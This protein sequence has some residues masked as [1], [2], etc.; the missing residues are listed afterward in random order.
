MRITQLLVVAFLLTLSGP[1]GAA[2][3]AIQIAIGRSGD[4]FILDTI[5]DFPVPVSTAWQVLTDFDHMV[6]VVSSLTMSKITAQNGNTLR[7]Q[8]SGVAKF[9]ILSYAFV[10]EREVTL[11]PMKR[12]SARQLSGNARQFSS[13]LE[14]TP[15]GNRA[16]A[17]YHAELT[18][19]S[20]LALVFG[21][22]FIKHELEEQF[23]AMAAEM[24]RRRNS[25]P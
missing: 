5:I 1:A 3:P 13:D 20:G 24:S 4:S 23:T 14:L 15:L 17:H 9:G 12:I 22:S 21:S 11:N 2:E 10:S 6:G 19:D 25:T 16:Q 8:Q 18:P 7:V